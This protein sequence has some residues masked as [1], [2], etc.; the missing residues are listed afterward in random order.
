MGTR[1]KMLLHWTTPVLVGLALIGASPAASSES[2][3]FAP[4]DVQRYRFQLELSDASNVIFGLADLSLTWLGT[5]AEQAELQLDLVSAS[6][7]GGMEATSVTVA[8]EGSA[9]STSGF[10][11]SH[12]NDRLSLNFD[13]DRLPESGSRITVQVAYHGVPANGLVISEDRHGQRTFFGDNWPDRARHWLPVIDHPSDKA[14]VTFEVTAPTTYQVIGVGELVSERDVDQERRVTTWA[15]RHPVPTKVMVIGA[16]RFAIERTQAVRGVPIESWIFAGDYPE[17]NGAFDE[18]KSVVEF[19]VDRIG[20]F[21][22]AK[23]ANVQSKTMF[24]G[25]E[26]ASAIFYSEAAVSRGASEGLVAHEIAH[27]WFGDSVTE[28][29]WSH[30]WLSEGFATYMTQLYLEW[31]YG[32]ERIEE[33]MRTAR[34]RVVQLSKTA[35]ASVIPEQIDDLMK[36]LSANSYQKGAW[37]LHM[38]R[39]RVGNDVFWQSI[40]SYYARH[41]DSN[42]T[43]DQF[44]EVVEETL[45]A[46]QPDPEVAL[47]LGWFFE[48]WLERPGQPAVTVQV[49][50]A[51]KNRVRL[52]GVQAPFAPAAKPFK[53]SL[54][55]ELIAADGATQTT[56]LEFDRWRAETVLDTELV[57]IALVLDPDAWLLFEDQSLTED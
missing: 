16:A 44:R 34:R 55:V 20:E 4:V 8:S 50:P 37:V 10:S 27:Q 29:D 57:P 17:A 22:Y 25:M 14:L 45:Q 43:T 40:R 31:R 42:A 23:L 3:A 12:L 39:R 9:P 32:S 18:T 47:D 19:F 38:L 28:A 41:R 6:E 11:W 52:Q 5:S 53:F 2:K 21:P 30:V 33:G 1:N 49:E 26:N 7:Q 13:A 35:P 48:Q 54:E 56:T 46:S 15:S 51:G 24:G 36:L